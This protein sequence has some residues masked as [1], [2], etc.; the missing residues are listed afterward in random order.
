MIALEL[1]GPS[2]GAMQGFFRQGNR[3]QWVS[4]INKR[5]FKS[6]F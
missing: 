1:S 2:V 6:I 3:F 5:L 4:Q